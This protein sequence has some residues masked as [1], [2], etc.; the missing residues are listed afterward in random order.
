MEGFAYFH[1]TDRIPAARADLSQWL[2]EGRL[3]MAEEILDG[4]ERYPEALQF[5]YTGGNIGKLMVRATT[6]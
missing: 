3:I 2:D 1:F 6:D 5:M 4:I